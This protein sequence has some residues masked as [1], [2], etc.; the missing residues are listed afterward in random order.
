MKNISAFK[1]LLTAGAFLVAS[2]ACKKNNEYRDAE[3]VREVNM[4]TYDFI[5]SR[6]NGLYDTLVY[7]LDKTGLAQK[8]KTGK[9]TF[10]VPQDYSISAAM[11]NLNFTREK[12]GDRGN[13]TVDSI[14]IGIWDT[15]LTRYMIEGIYSLDSLMIA[16]GVILTTPYGY[17]MNGKAIATTASGVAKSGSKVIQYSDRNNSRVIKNW[18]MATTESAN[19]KTTNGIVH[20]LEPKHIFG[21]SSFIPMA[22][23]SV[24]TPYQGKPI[25]LPGTIELAYFDKGGETVAY[26]DADPTNKG[27]A[28]FRIDDG[29]DIDNCSEGLYNLGYTVTG[30]WLKYTVKVDFAG[31]YYLR[32]RAASPNSNSVFH[33]ELDDVTVNGPQVVPKTGGYQTWVTIEGGKVYLT[34]GVHTVTYYEETGGY[35]GS[36][37]GFTPAFRV[38][39]N[40]QPLQIPGTIP[41]AYFDYGDEGVSYHD[42]DAFNK[43]SAKAVFRFFEGP[44]IDIANEGGYNI[45][46][47]AAGE[48]TLYTVDVAKTGSYRL[49]ARVA[50]P[51][52]TGKFHFEIDGVNITGTM[53]APNTGAYQ[54]FTNVTKTVTLQAGRHD[55]KFYAESSSFNIAKFNFV[56]L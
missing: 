35:N 46:G 2:A 53:A 29:V 4:N 19:L 11:Y 52:T 25:Y 32:S 27:T 24:R 47:T 14:R 21:Y 49:E 20:F 6:N 17:E 42:T 44:D 9:Y 41:A 1:L 36:K 56:A 54:T 40:G 33:V 18:V 22:Y 5:K 15:L 45:G 13:W 8:L 31:M 12:R 37:I 38:P 55:L 34:E 7:L 48:W 50:S 28:R 30:E 43:G 39:F 51:Y 10:F 16:D 23:P 3:P 26:H